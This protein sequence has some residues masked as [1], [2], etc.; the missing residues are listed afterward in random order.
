M[1]ASLILGD[2]GGIGI[3]SFAGPWCRISRT[4]MLSAGSPGTITLPFRPPFIMDARVSIAN[5]PLWLMLKW[6]LPQFVMRIGRT[7]CE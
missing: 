6:H 2:F 3:G 7:L 1:S 4:S 5:P